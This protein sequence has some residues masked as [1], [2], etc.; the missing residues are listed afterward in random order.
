MESPKNATYKEENGTLIA[1]TKEKI[2]MKF[3]QIS[4]N[5]TPYLSVHKYQHD[6]SCA[7]YVP[8]VI[9]FSD[10]PVFMF[11]DVPSLSYF[12][13]F[14]QI[15]VLFGGKSSGNKVLNLV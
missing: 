11:K 6:S 4:L 14:F 15:V 13:T 5:I 1:R 7:P 8:V 9:L 2:F 3:L 12:L 10:L